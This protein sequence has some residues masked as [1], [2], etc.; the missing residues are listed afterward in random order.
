M[1]AAV[2]AEGKHFHLVE[3]SFPLALALVGVPIG[4]G[5]FIPSR[6]HFSPCVSRT[7]RALRVRTECEKSVDWGMGA[8]GISSDKVADFGKF[9]LVASK[10]PPALI[11]RAVANSRKSFP[12][13]SVPRTNTGI[14]S[15]RRGCTLRSESVLAMTLQCFYGILRAKLW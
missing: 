10:I 11:F 12:W 4:R 13:S 5:N 15:G 7:R 2:Y 3:K 14:D 9:R 8:T 1:G 6:L